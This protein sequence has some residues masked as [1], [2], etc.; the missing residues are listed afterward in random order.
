MAHSTPWPQRF[1]RHQRKP[2]SE[3]NHVSSLCLVLDTHTIWY[4]ARKS[5]T[6]T[7]EHLVMKYKPGTHHR[8]HLCSGRCVLVGYTS[9]ISIVPV[10]HY[11]CSS[12]NIYEPT[13]VGK[14]LPTFGHQVG[15]STCLVTVLSWM[16]ICGVLIYVE[17]FPK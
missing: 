1:Q 16:L 8:H 6:Y 11:W 3:S 4:A 12:S 2:S 13:L 9:P 10:Y 15:K 7:P 5:M 14:E 17:T